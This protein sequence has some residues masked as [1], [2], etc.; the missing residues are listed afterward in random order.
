M[1]ENLVTLTLGN[2]DRNKFN[3][4]LTVFYNDKTQWLILP[5]SQNML[6]ILKQ[7]QLISTEP[8]FFLNGQGPKVLKTLVTSLKEENRISNLIAKAV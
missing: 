8:N 7:N 3:A 2:L 5:Y 1:A 4:A 6:E